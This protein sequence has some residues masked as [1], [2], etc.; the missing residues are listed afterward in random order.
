MCERL[1][2]AA[3]E[4]D[5]VASARRAHRRNTTFQPRQ[6]AQCLHVLFSDLVAVTG[7][8][9]VPGGAARVKPQQ[10]VQLRPLVIVR[11]DF[12][13]GAALVSGLR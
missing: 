12:K 2:A 8:E 7:K 3:G 6:E 10:R 4:I 1:P 11:T 9:T 13:I 5:N